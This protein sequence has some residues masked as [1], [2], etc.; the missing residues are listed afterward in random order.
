MKEFW[1]EN[2]DEYLKMA[3]ANDN[4]KTIKMF[5]VENIDGDRVLLKAV[6]YLRTTI[7]G[8]QKKFATLLETA[9]YVQKLVAHGHFRGVILEVGRLE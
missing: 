3:D 4:P 7:M 6:T 2:I 9:E 1:F 5:S 8:W